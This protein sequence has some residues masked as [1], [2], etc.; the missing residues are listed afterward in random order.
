MSKSKKHG[1]VKTLVPNE[2]GQLVETQEE[3]STQAETTQSRKRGKRELNLDDPFLKQEIVIKAQSNP[4]RKGSKAFQRF[5]LYA[6]NMTVAD[7]LKAG[8]TRG[9]INWDSQHEHI[10]LRQP[11]KAETTE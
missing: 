3:T 9:D 2:D 4:K 6:P 5:E 7:F 10:E 11:L 1:E 8:G